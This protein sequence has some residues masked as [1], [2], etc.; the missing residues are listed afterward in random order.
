MK[1]FIIYIFLL[2]FLISNDIKA[3]S[4]SELFGSEGASGIANPK[5]RSLSW[6][7]Q[8]LTFSG[9]TGLILNNLYNSGFFEPFGLQP[10]IYKEMSP[11]AYDKSLFTKS[12]ERNLKNSKDIIFR[13]NEIIQINNNA[14]STQPKFSM[15]KKE[16]EVLFN[17]YITQKKNRE[18]LIR[19][20]FD[21]R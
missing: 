11:L 21:E 6:S 10:E 5:T 8:Y 7:M 15:I 14:L 16:N 17:D 20:L 9:A 12:I 3:G 1:R 2:L 13:K 19:R 4:F 18:L